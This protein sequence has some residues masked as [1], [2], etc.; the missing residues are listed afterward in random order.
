MTR[1]VSIP[2]FKSLRLL[3]VNV[4]NAPNN[5]FFLGWLGDILTLAGDALY[6]TLLDQPVYKD[7]LLEL[8]KLGYTMSNRLIEIDIVAVQVQDIIDRY[9]EICV[10]YQV[11]AG[12]IEVVDMDAESIKIL[13]RSEDERPIEQTL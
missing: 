11:P 8:V 13:I 6:D 4:D 5:Q 12:R 1:V 3:T 9:Q 7:K 10:T 2:Y